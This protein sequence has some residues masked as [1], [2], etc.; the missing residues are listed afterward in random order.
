M[1]G[2]PFQTIICIAYTTGLRNATLD[3]TKSNGNGDSNRTR[4][5]ASGNRNRNRN[6]NRNYNKRPSV[7]ITYDEEDFP[8]LTTPV[9]P[10]LSPPTRTPLNKLNRKSVSAA[11]PSKKD[12]YASH[13][14]ATSSIKGSNTTNNKTHSNTSS[15][16][17]SDETTT[18]R[19][20]T[21]AQWW[22]QLL[23]ATGGKLELPKCFYYLLNWVF[24]IEG[25]ARLATPEELN[26]QITL[27]QSTYAQDVNITQR[28]CTASHRTLDAH[29]NPPGNL[30]TELEHLLSKGKKMAHLISAQLIT[31]FEACISECCS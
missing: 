13:T 15:E 30:Q 8:K 12:T 10:T 23:H 7:T 19:L 27:R 1:E 14:A 6:R 11:G 3:I 17:R 24:D 5:R 26:I 25:E 28:C 31:R 2:Q 29:E 22:E 21:A 4:T 16:H 9:T 20:K 18:P